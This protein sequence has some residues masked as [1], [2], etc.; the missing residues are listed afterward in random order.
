ME[1][2]LHEVA[3]GMNE[4]EQ[5][6]VGGTQ[7]LDRRLPGERPEG[8]KARDV[9]QAT[10]AVNNDQVHHI[11][12]GQN[13]A[14]LRK[15]ATAEMLANVLQTSTRRHA[16]SGLQSFQKVK[17]FQASRFETIEDVLCGW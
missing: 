15:T 11:C 2:C 16:H 4:N 17:T 3:S 7:F 6:A 12:G 5:E 13:Q 1:H 9:K 14:K 8:M 10:V